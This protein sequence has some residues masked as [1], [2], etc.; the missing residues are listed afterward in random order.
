VQFGDGVKGARLPTG[1]NNLRFSYRQGLGTAGNLRA[2]QLTMLLTRPAGVTRV[3]NP[4]PSTGGQDPETIDDAR[5]HAPFH[6]LTLDRAVSTEDYADF[7]ATFAGVA[8]AHSVW[9]GSG[10]ARGIYVTIA[11]P[12]AETFEPT[13]DT[14]VSLTKALRRFGDELLPIRVQSFLNATFSLSASVKV[15]DDADSTI[16]LPAVEAA[17]RRSY[18]FTAA[19][20]GEPVTLD[21][22]Y[23]KMQAVSGVVAVNISELYRIDTGPAPLEPE[24]R[25]LAKLPVLQADGSVSPA[26]LLTLDPMPLQLG[27]MP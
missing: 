10:P 5:R 26:E 11:G 17:L 1:Q 8:K 22:V 19:D 9:I 20:F 15:A 4:A 21:G 2:G 23:A 25:L 18:S 16:V 6:V 27:A 14:L 13:D 7:A 12:N 3:S 24:A